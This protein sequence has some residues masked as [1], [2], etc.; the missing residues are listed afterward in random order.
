MR[1][2]ALGSGIL[3]CTCACIVSVYKIILDFREAWAHERFKWISRW[4][5]DLQ[6]FYNTCV[7]PDGPD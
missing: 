3:T 4:L 1:I 2:L 5:L 7:L 6:G